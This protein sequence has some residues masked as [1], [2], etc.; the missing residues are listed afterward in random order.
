MKSFILWQQN[1]RQN[2]FNRGG[3]LY[4]CAG[5]LDILKIDQNSTDS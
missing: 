3:G 5:G 2:V 4:V 1:R